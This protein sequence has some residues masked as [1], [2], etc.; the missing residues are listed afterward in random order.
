MLYGRGIEGPR[1]VSVDRGC[2]VLLFVEAA[3]AAIFDRAH[4]AQSVS[5]KV[6]INFLK[7]GRLY[8]TKL[9]FSLDSI[10]EFLSLEELTALFLVREAELFSLAAPVF[11]FQ[12][13][14]LSNISLEENVQSN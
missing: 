12:L 10:V 9:G 3:I 5:L 1:L 7:S 4:V 11:G 14:L 8:L 6:R 13:C 2:C